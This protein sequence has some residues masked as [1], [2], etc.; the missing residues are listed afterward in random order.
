[1][2][3]LPTLPRKYHSASI[4]A[5]YVIGLCPAAWYFYEALTGRLGFNPVREFEHLLGTW[6]LRLIIATLVITPLR[7][8]FG[9]NWMRYRRAV[10][11]LAFYYVLMH[12][13]VYLTLD[14]Q[15]DFGAVGGDI[16][17]RPY[18][19]IGFAALVL[20]VPLA[21]TSNN[22]S[23]RKL[24]GAWNRLHKLVYPIAMGGL[25]HYLL[26]LKS[27]TLE[28]FVYIVLM[29]V[30]LAYRIVRRPMLDW[31]RGRRNA[32]QPLSPRA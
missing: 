23:I 24:S 29:V 9:L 21:V 3:F 8:L 30:L 13:A 17:R 22:W 31:K 7:D 14:L 6:G 25:V 28:P 32:R 10:G 18:I 27:I 19:T 16:L 2:A 11:L 1:M 15:F 26:S 4:W 20:L 12:F 5:L